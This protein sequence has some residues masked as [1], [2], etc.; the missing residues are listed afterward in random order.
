MRVVEP[1]DS[2]LYD[3]YQAQGLDISHLIK[4]K[5]AGHGIGKALA[6]LYFEQAPPDD[7]FEVLILSEFGSLKAFLKADTLIE[8]TA[9]C[10]LARRLVRTGHFQDELRAAALDYDGNLSQALGYTEDD[11]LR[12]Y[13]GALGEYLM[14]SDLTNPSTGSGNGK[15]LSFLE[16]MLRRAEEAWQA[17]RILG[18]AQDLSEKDKRY[19]HREIAQRKLLDLWPQVQLEHCLYMLSEL[20]EHLE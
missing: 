13:G 17:S 5:V 18:L 3:Q 20:Q 10:V 11:P 4:A 14:Q 7:L 15:K 1:F 9:V 2:Q 19:F 16:A 12:V 8:E 6:L